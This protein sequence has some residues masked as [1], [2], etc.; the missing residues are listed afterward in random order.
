MG[1]IDEVSSVKN[2]N[3]EDDD[4]EGH[5]RNVRLEAED[6]DA[7]EESD[8]D[9][10]GHVRNAPGVKNVKNVKNDAAK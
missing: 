7:G 6:V 3:E 2:E 1:D 9:F 5:V 10:E 8:D 4:F